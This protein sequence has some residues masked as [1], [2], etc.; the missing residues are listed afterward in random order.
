M[1]KNTDK[2]PRFEI[3]NEVYKERHPFPC[4]DS[5][6]QE[7]RQGQTNTKQQDTSSNTQPKTT[8]TTT[9]K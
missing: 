7:K 2:K 9:K 8:Q 6:K 5:N 3:A 1:N 4:P